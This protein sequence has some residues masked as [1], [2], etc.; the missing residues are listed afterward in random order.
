MKESY[1][2]TPQGMSVLNSIKKEISKLEGL[3]PA[4]THIVKGDKD[5]PII[6][7]DNREELDEK[8]AKLLAKISIKK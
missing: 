6:V 7:T 4:K 2:G 3:Y 5:N 8:I 1:K